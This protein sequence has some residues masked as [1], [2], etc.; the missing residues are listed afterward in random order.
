MELFNNNIK[1]IILSG[2]T[3]DNKLRQ[4]AKTAELELW[5]NSSNYG[6]VELT[7]ETFLHSIC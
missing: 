4:L 7:H 6:I 2:F 1:F 5:V 3:S